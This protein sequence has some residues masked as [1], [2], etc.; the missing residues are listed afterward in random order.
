MRDARDGSPRRDIEATLTLPLLTVT[1]WH[2]KK[3]ILIVF[4][5]VML[6]AAPAA[7]AFSTSGFQNPYGIV[8]DPKA[9]YIYISNVNG[10][11]S[12]VDDNGFIS[13]LKG[14]GT[15]DNLRFIDGAT[16][17][18]SLNAPKGMAIVGTTLYI[19]DI[20]KLR[21]FDISSGKYL[22]DV[23]FGDLP[24][25]HFYD[26]SSGPDEALYLAD[27]PAN[28]IYR[29][30]VPK[31]HEVTT[32]VSGNQL[33]QPHGICWHRE[34]QVFLLAG[35]SSGQVT[36]YDRAGKRQ[37]TP[38]VFL[39]TLE[40]IRTDDAGNTFVASTALGAVY[41]IASNFALYSFGLGL[42]SPAGLTFNKG[43]NEI[44]V[45][46]FDTGTVQS[47]PIQLSSQ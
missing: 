22:F 23:N 28:V 46:S 36:A 43:T 14:D 4:S 31:L 30:D 42:N 41:R 7:R 33:G 19:A 2:M 9:N 8:I 24:V 12:A 17:N 39:R 20:D 27:G 26:I 34:R 3:I 21:A 35:W 13:R 6:F 29:I 32:L 5:I 38:A 10:N 40:G 18:I 11:P 37:A 16:P 45:A 15:V 1:L 25:Q 47:I 44:L